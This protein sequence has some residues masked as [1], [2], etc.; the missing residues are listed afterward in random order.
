MRHTASVA[1]P[2]LPCHHILPLS[3][4]LFSASSHPHLLTVSSTTA[5]WGP[6]AHKI[7]GKDHGGGFEITWTIDYR[8]RL[9]TPI[10]DMPGLESS[11]IVARTLAGSIGATAPAAVDQVDR[12]YSGRGVRG[13]ISNSME[14]PDFRSLMSVD[15][16]TWY[17][18][19]GSVPGASNSFYALEHCGKCKPKQGGFH[20]YMART[21]FVPPPALPYDPSADLLAGPPAATPAPASGAPA[22]VLAD[23]WAWPHL[24]VFYDHDGSFLGEPGMT[25][26]AD[27][28]MLRDDECWRYLGGRICKADLEFRRFMLNNHAPSS[29]KFNALLVTDTETGMTSR[30]EF[31]NYNASGY[32]FTAV[33]GREYE[34]SWDTPT[35]VDPEKFRLHKVDYLDP[36]HWVRFVT[37]HAED[38]HHVDVNGH[39]AS[40]LFSPSFSHAVPAPS[41][42]LSAYAHSPRS[43]K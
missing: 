5:G 3:L 17:G 10:S 9:D 13:L 8:R 43:P 20:T 32:Q 21:T 35:R 16:V 27:N 42:V 38:Y 31:S 22:T 14:T 23:D 7:N 39:K 33:T 6:R 1:S 28:G 40:A 2:H 4:S 37:R 36:E 18:F 25:L 24:G 26:H 29:L 12:T 34:L 30:V 15:D 41:Y 11:F 19:T